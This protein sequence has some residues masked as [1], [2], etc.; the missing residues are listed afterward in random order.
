LLDERRDVSIARHIQP[1]GGGV[2]QVGGHRHLDGAGHH[3]VVCRAR[4]AD[5]G[6]LAGRAVAEHM[7]PGFYNS[8]V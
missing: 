1:T 6:Q 4:K 3:V 2:D 5:I 7:D 8:A